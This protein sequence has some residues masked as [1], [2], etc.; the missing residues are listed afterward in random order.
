M[1]RWK[2]TDWIGRAR[3]Y[4]EQRKAVVPGDLILC[5][6]FQDGRITVHYVEAVRKPAISQSGYMWTVAPWFNMATHQAEAVTAEIDPAWF[7]PLRDVDL[8]SLKEFEFLDP[9]GLLGEDATSIA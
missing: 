9:A 4:V 1:G 7:I 2:G 8:D 3:P 5:D 6:L